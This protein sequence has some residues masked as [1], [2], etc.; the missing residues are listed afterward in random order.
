VD[1]YAH[2]VVYVDEY[3]TS[4]ASLFSIRNW[5]G[6]L[7]GGSEHSS[8]GYCVAGFGADAGFAYHV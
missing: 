8:S 4:Q 3:Y 5:Q 1:K 7:W 6:P 2:L